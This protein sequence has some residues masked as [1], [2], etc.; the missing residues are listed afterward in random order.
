MTC[1]SI[2]NP[3]SQRTDTCTGRT[4]ALRVVTQ[5]SCSVASPAVGVT[6][7]KFFAPGSLD[8]GILEA[9]GYEDVV[10]LA[11]EVVFG[12]R[13]GCSKLV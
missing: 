6:T 11:F 13:A 12:D 9:E 8:S 10:A 4:R 1:D 7:G 5:S 2:S 3:R